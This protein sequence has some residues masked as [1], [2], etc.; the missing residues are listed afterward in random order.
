MQ[1]IQIIPHYLARIS[2]GGALLC[3]YF[4]NLCVAPAEILWNVGKSEY[5]QGNILSSIPFFSLAVAFGVIFGVFITLPSYIFFSVF[6]GFAG[7]CDAI[8]HPVLWWHAPVTSFSNLLALDLQPYFNLR[9][10]QR[11]TS[12]ND[13]EQIHPI[14]NGPNYPHILTVHTAKLAREALLQNTSRELLASCQQGSGDQIK[15]TV[16]EDLWGL[17]ADKVSAALS[18]EFPNLTPEEIGPIIDEFVTNRITYSR[19]V[20]IVFNATE[21]VEMAK[22]IVSNSVSTGISMVDYGNS[23]PINNQGL[24]APHN[25]LG[26]GTALINSDSQFITYG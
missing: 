3:R 13:D 9:P 20:S 10:V 25:H 11:I 6:A 24:V 7:L 22:K 26:E 18:S 4:G 5:D 16:N 21:S 17:I 23:G 19:S 1:Q 15:W 2:M 14:Y 12:V 8:A